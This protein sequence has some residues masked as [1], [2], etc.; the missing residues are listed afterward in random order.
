MPQHT[1]FEH[2]LRL[3]ETSLRKL[4]T[5]YNMFFSGQRVRPPWE[6][7]RR[8]ETMLTRLDRA[9]IASSVDRFRLGTLQSRFVTLS[10][11]WDRALRAREEGRPGPFAKPRRQTSDAEPPARVAAGIG[12]A[13]DVPAA[14]SPQPRPRNRV[15]GTATLAGAEADGGKLKALYESLVEARTEVGA[16]DPLPFSRFAGIVE[17]QLARLRELGSSEVAFR[18]AV[19]DGR[20]VLTARGMKAAAG[21]DSK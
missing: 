15:V 17:G 21:D 20:V 6:G 18:V 19:K 16:S 13:E 12:A 14:A 8:L 5:E 4:E 9:T 1:E 11:L 10:E 7:R 2:E 3:I